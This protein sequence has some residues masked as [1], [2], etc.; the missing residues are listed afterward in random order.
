MND[1]IADRIMAKGV[2]FAQIEDAAAALMRIVSD[3]SIH[4]KDELQ[5]LTST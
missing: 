4:G 2:I 5:S 3:D 1:A